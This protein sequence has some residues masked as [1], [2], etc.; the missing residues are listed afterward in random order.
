MVQYTKHLD[1]IYK[2]QIISIV[3][4]W[5]TNQSRPWVDLAL[6]EN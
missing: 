5:Q 6:L 4:Q 2:F 1:N 3:V